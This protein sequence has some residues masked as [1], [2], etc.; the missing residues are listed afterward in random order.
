MFGR[1]SR[2]RL[3]RA[4]IERL[5]SQHRAA[6]YVAEGAEDARQL[7]EHRERAAN[8]D[9]EQAL[10]RLADANAELARWGLEPIPRDVPESPEHPT[11]YRRSSD[12]RVTRSGEELVEL[13]ETYATCSPEGVDVTVTEEPSVLPCVPG[14]QAAAWGCIHCGTLDYRIAC[15]GRQP[16][17][18]AELVAAPAGAELAAEAH[19]LR[20]ELA[21]V[22]GKL[23]EALITEE[24]LRESVAI[25]KEAMR[26]ANREATSARAELDQLATSPGTRTADAEAEVGRLHHRISDLQGD[27]NVYR[28][29][30][31]QSNAEAERCRAELADALTAASA[32]EAVVDSHA[33]QLALQRVATE[34]AERSRDRAVAKADQLGLELEALRAGEAFKVPQVGDTFTVKLRDGM[35]DVR[36]RVLSSSPVGDFG[37]SLMLEPLIDTAAE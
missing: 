20:L 4:A 24:G 28:D 8:A 12:W 35:G 16:V 36:C 10:Q 21:T 17:E 26:E 11:R 23:A 5:E 9:R 37:F 7:A 27:V 18:A 15:P 22:R 29:A 31:Q 19:R 6:K 3:A 14:T 32:A 2:R 1:I 30:A 13:L 34:Q 25:A 33:E